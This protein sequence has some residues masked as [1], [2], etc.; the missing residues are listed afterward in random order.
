[1]NEWNDDEVVNAVT[2]RA[3]YDAIAKAHIA[4]N[5]TDREMMIVQLNNAYNLGV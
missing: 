2:D 3:S 5:Q 1:M 4:L